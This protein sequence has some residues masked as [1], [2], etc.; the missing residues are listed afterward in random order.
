MWLLHGLEATTGVLSEKPD[1]S[2]H[3]IATAR[4][5]LDDRLAGQIQTRRLHQA[6]GAS[7]S[8]QKRTPSMGPLSRADLIFGHLVLE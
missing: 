4:C 6:A 1:A 2:S 5:R 7:E 3:T 8:S